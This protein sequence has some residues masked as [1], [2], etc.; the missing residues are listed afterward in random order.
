[1][2]RESDIIKEVIEPQNLY[3]SIA[4]VMR[5]RRRKRTRIGRWIMRNEDK[6]VN[7]LSRQ[8]EDGTFRITGYEERMVTDG[9]KVRRVQSIAYTADRRECRD[10][11]RG[12]QGVPQVHTHDIRLHQAQGYA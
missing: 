1:M 12:A 6:V 11:C 9:P 4:V 5:G 3:N 2:K 8:I 7:M 10:E